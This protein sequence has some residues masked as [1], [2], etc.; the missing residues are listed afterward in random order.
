MDLQV[1][2]IAA[3]D[4]TDSEIAS[5]AASVRAELERFSGVEGVRD[6]VGPAPSG[7]KAIGLVQ[8]GDFLVA[9]KPTI[10]MLTALI[11]LANTILK[12]A[13][14]PPM[15]L[16]VAHGAIEVE[17]DPRTISPAEVIAEAK[18]LLPP[19]G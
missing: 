5:A 13:G 19:S 11:M 3:G 14:T 18:R 17:F 16:K 2:L 9:A 8:I 6:I 12:Q 7:A 4:T 10:E 1:R 15:K